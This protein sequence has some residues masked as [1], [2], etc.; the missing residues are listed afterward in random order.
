MTGAFAARLADATDLDTVQ[1]D[2]GATV[3]QALAPSHVSLWLS[4]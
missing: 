1:S 3:N 2:L 4:R